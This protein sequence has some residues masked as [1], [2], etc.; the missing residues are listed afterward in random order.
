MKEGSYVH[1]PADLP[2]P[3]RSQV[4]AHLRLFRALSTLP[5]NMASFSSHKLV[6]CCGLADALGPDWSFTVGSWAH[7]RQPGRW[8]RRARAW[9]PGSCTLGLLEALFCT[10]G[11]VG[12]DSESQVLAHSRRPRPRA[13]TPFVSTSAE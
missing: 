12:L 9:G 1:G 4:T 11:R 7:Q 6:V 2:L 8:A 5:L 10:H 13:V 3:T